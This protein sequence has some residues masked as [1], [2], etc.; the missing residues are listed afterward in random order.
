[1]AEIFSEDAESGTSGNSVTASTSNFDTDVNGSLSITYTNQW[2]IEGTKSIDIIGTSWGNIQGLF[3]SSTATPFMSVYVQV[4]SLPTEVN[5]FLF[6]YEG[7]T[8]DFVAG[9]TM[10][11]DG[12]LILRDATGGAVGTATTKQFGINDVF[13]LDYASNNPSNSQ[14]TLRIFYGANLHGTTP[15]ETKTATLTN[16]NAIQRFGIG[17]RNTM[18]SPGLHIRLDRIKVSNSQFVSPASATTNG[19]KV[20]TAADVWTTAAAKRWSGSVWQACVA[21]VWNGTQWVT[22]G[23]DPGGDTTPPTSPGSPTASV[24]GVNVS[25][26][27]GASTD[28]VA[29]TGYRIY[30]STTSGFVPPS[31]GTMVG[32]SIT[33]SFTNTYVPEGTYY[34]KIIAYDAAGNISTPSAQTSATITSGGSTRFYADPGAGK[35]YVGS[36]PYLATFGG[37]QNSLTQVNNRLKNPLNASSTNFGN[38]NSGTTGCPAAPLSTYNSGVG[39]N[40]NR[41]MG[42][43]RS[44]NSDSSASGT[45][46]EVSDINASINVLGL[47]FIS[48]KWIGASAAE[49]NELAQGG[50]RD[51]LIQEWANIIKSYH[52]WPIWWCFWH[53]PNDNYDSDVSNP[54]NRRNKMNAY[55]AAQRNIVR[56]FRQEEVNNAA[57]FPA[58]YQNTHWRS[59][60]NDVNV[61]GQWPDLIG[62]PDEPYQS[63]GWAWNPSPS[64]VYS[65]GSTNS[66]VDG[67]SNDVYPAWL[68]TAGL[69]G[70][71]GYR[72]KLQNRYDE[73]YNRMIVTYPTGLPQVVG[74][75]TMPAYSASPNPATERSSGG[76]TS[77]AHQNSLTHSYSG[78]TAG[79]YAY[80]IE[81]RNWMLSWNEFMISRGVIAHCLFGGA[82]QANNPSECNDF[83][84]RLVWFDPHNARIQGL[85]EIIDDPRT[86][87]VN[88]V[89]GL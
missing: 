34:Y 47:P 22:S 49:M 35:V 53:E 68:P 45:G 86:V 24:S 46:P 39:N 17:N 65:Y 36:N 1:M 7:S 28:N 20:R 81:S 26:S 58:T 42:I 12:A 75:Y 79:N 80:A 27:W 60:K 89:L 15:N 70:S 73:F 4:V 25:L 57:F 18:V 32:T 31:A 9:V 62:D 74:E 76:V 21:K 54:S 85:A 71:S 51:A 55:R 87:T 16:I 78:A 61:W 43:I 29:V 14:Q 66:V 10:Q 88:D 48:W 41:Y 77:F 5:H 40:S 8:T 84:E 44:Y 82:T 83:D 64:E 59:E 6:T 30:R 13:R 56:I 67:I 23:Y 11:P 52:P 3:S 33:N 63:G 37:F 72:L 19:P 2:A 69:T 38:G 50:S